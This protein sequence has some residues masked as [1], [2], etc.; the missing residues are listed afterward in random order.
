M[1]RAATAVLTGALAA[2]LLLAGCAEKAR[3]TTTAAPPAPAA[4]PPPAP[5]APRPAPSRDDVFVVVPDADG[6]AGKVVIVQDGREIVLD[7]PYATARTVPAGRL[8]RGTLSASDVDRMF[9]ATLAAQPPAPMA[10]RLYFVEGKEEFTQE[11]AH[12]LRS[13][14]DE[15]KRRPDP[16]VV[17]VGH[18]DSVGGV[19]ANDRLSLQ[20][21]ERV[22]QELVRIGLPAGSISVAGRGERELLVPTADGVAEP[23]NRRVEIT[24]R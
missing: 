19:A 23:R 6:R 20:R 3:E 1:T 8:E 5:P 10:V 14:L 9:G 2:S 4:P 18:T 11:S 12:A 21:A 15:I 13:V 16:E 17:V 22:R 24:V 7:A